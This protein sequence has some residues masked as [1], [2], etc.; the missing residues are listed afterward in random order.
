M[1]EKI[2]H[3]I[4]GL[5]NDFWLNFQTND[6]E[7]NI[8]ALTAISSVE[9][10]NIWKYFQDNPEG[11]RSLTAEQ[12][13]SLSLILGKV[14]VKFPGRRIIIIGPDFLNSTLPIC[15][16]DVLIFAKPGQDFFEE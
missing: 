4:T 3:T 6:P 9:K 14:A 11:L 7:T 2:N 15:E 16:N 8:V 12:V 5:G 10:G 13:N 1:A